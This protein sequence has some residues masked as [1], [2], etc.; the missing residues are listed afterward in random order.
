MWAKGRRKRSDRLRLN[1]DKT[2]TPAFLTITL[3]AWV[4]MDTSCSD[5]VK[6]PR[7]FDYDQCTGVVSL[8][9]GYLLVEKLYHKRTAQ[10]A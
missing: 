5:H 10:P 7:Q 9:G 3:R 4:I 8:G 1:I 2:L 6:L